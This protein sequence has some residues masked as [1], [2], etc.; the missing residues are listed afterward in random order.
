MALGSWSNVSNVSNLTS[1]T[2]NGN[3]KNITNATGNTTTALGNTTTTQ[4]FN[5]FAVNP[6]QNCLN[7]LEQI[8]TT[9]VAATSS[10]ALICGCGGSFGGGLPIVSVP[11]VQLA[12]TSCSQGLYSPL[13][14]GLLIYIVHCLGASTAFMLAH[15]YGSE[16]DKEFYFQDIADR[17]ELAKMTGQAVYKDEKAMSKQRSERKKKK[18][19]SETQIV[20]FKPAPKDEAPEPL[21][22]VGSYRIFTV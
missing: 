4:A 14:F 21:G 5:A 7:A 6:G 9:T 10:Q 16:A 20:V 22:E 19:Q 8:G 2:W 11:T 1:T 13:L 17:R 12:V 3:L 15:Q 18:K